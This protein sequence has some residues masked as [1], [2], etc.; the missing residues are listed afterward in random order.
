[1]SDDWQYG[2]F[3]FFV[4][5]AVFGTI[6]KA[7]DLSNSAFLLATGA[8]SVLAAIFAAIWF[9]DRKAFPRQE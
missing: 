4:A 5:L 1:M 7:L 2:A 9:L 6:G 3:W 8:V